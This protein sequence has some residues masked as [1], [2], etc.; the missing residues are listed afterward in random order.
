MGNPEHNM[1][2]ICIFAGSSPGRRVEYKEAAQFLAKELVSRGFGIVYGG[3]KVGLMGILADSVLKQGGQVIGVM[4]ESLV[5]RE[6]AHENLTEL[7]VVSTMQERKNTMA[8]L[9]DGF[10][11]LPGGF[12]TIE[13]II[14]VLTWAQLG[15]HQKPCGVL[16]ICGFCKD[17]LS[18]LEKCVKERFLKKEHKSMILVDTS[19]KLLLDRFEAYR[20]PVVEKW[21]DRV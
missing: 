18:F 4:P 12:G 2:N 14:E 19:P 17:F 3:A 9:S 8:G 20:A 13:E 11:A 5:Q 21:I 16:D 6:V 15:F 10:V 1:K 7:H